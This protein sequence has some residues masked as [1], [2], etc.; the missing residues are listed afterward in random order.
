MLLEALLKG[1]DHPNARPVVKLA[2]EMI[3]SAAKNINDALAKHQKLFKVFGSQKELNAMS[4][5]GVNR[6]GEVTIMTSF[7]AKSLGMI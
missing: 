2:L 5:G 7:N 4:S 3:S 1:C 6:D